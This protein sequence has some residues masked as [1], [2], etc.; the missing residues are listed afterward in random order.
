MYLSGY[1][2]TPASGLSSR[3]VEENANDT[4][5]GTDE[6]EH[7]QKNTSGDGDDRIARRPAPLYRPRPRN[8]EALR[9]A[10]HRDRQRIPRA[11]RVAQHRVSRD[12]T[13][14]AGA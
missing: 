13:R 6:K 14:D 5:G 9:R 1:V 11:H 12:S 8:E 2:T 10:D 3:R 4:E 7:F